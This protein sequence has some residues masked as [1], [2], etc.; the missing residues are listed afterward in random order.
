MDFGFDACFKLFA[1]G[2][3][4]YANAFSRT[5]THSW[6]YLPGFVEASVNPLLAQLNDAI[7]F[8]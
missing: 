3:D 8:P 6:S 7:L 5:L 1:S 4:T 2:L